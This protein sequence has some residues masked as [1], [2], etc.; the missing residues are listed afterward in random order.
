MGV[1][2]F[3]V[4]VADMEMQRVALVAFVF[5]RQVI[6]SV[7]VSGVLEERKSGVGIGV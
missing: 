1:A 5:A 4:R 2:F 7:S 3:F 6:V